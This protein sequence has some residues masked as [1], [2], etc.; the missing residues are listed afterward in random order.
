MKYPKFIK[1]F[2]MDEAGD[3]CAKLIKKKSF[4]EDWYISEIISYENDSLIYDENESYRVEDLKD[5]GLT[6]CKITEQEYIK[7]ISNQTKA[8]LEEEIKCQQEYLDNYTI[9]I[10]QKIEKLNAEISLL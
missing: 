1:I 2:D 4:D 6:F 10:N 3:W 9:E 8:Q 7:F 5:S